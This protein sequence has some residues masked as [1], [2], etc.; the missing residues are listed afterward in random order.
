MPVI[1]Y[2]FLTNPSC[3]LWSRICFLQSP[4]ADSSVAIKIKLLSTHTSQRI[5]LYSKIPS[6]IFTKFFNWGI[7]LLQIWASRKLRDCCDWVKGKCNS[8][9]QKHSHEAKSC[10]QIRQKRYLLKSVHTNSVSWGKK[11][12]KVKNLTKFSPSKN[13]KTTGSMWENSKYKTF[14]LIDRTSMGSS[15]RLD[16]YQYFFSSTDLIWRSSNNKSNR[17]FHKIKTKR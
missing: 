13:N 11:K 5:P 16:D 9:V 7:N 3:I 12:K 1:N 10:K 8:V 14:S 4:Q 6:V 17:R 15:S 2:F